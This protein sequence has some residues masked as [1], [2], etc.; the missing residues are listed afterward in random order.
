MMSL[1]RTPVDAYGELESIPRLTKLTLW[2][3][4][5]EDVSPDA[6]RKLQ[7]SGVEKEV[8]AM[9][10]DLAVEIPALWTCREHQALRVVCLV[11][12]RRLLEFRWFERIERLERYFII[13]WR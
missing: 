5:S 7:L 4:S 2:M 1:M 9:D 3:I 6:V 8:K 10:S 12:S 11:D 13:F